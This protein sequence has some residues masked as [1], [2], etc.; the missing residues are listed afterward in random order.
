MLKFLVERGVD[1]ST[2]EVWY[3]AYGESDPESKP[4]LIMADEFLRIGGRFDPKTTQRVPLY[5]LGGGRPN[6]EMMA[7]MAA[8]V[9]QHV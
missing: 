9:K 3:P 8:A 4:F 5:I 2:V 7:Q 6:P 1:L